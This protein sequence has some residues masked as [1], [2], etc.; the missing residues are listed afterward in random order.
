MAGAA[1]GPPLL[2]A[3]REESMNPGSRKGERGASLLEG[4]LAALMVG[5]AVVTGAGAWGRLQD[6]SA[7]R[8]LAQEVKSLASEAAFRAVLERTHVGLVFREGNGGVWA[9]LYR[10]GDG[11]GVSAEDIGRGVDRPL[12][13]AFLLRE[14]GA[15]TSIPAAVTVDPAG[16][17]LSPGDPVRF[18]RAE[19]LSFGPLGTATPGTLY[20]SSGDGREVFAFRTAGVDGRIRVFRWFRGRWSPAGS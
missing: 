19:T 18:G 1:S 4:S 5:M 6:Q 11:D 17:P 3:A 10:D 14:A 2:L 16:R 8:A 9:R 20:L 12:S 13:S 15:R 7:S